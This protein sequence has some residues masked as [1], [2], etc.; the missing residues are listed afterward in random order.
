MSMDMPD[1]TPDGLSQVEHG[2]HGL[3]NPNLRSSIDAT[4]LPHFRSFSPRG[5]NTQGDC[6]QGH[7]LS[8]GAPLTGNRLL[9]MSWIVGLGIT[10]AV[11][12]YRGQS[13]ISPTLD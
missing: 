3:T 2:L 12:F 9:T 10:K 11:C 8:L 1:L 13:L 5:G 4:Y 6:R 7:L